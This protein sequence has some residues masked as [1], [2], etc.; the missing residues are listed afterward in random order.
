MGS[1]CDRGRFR[2]GILVGEDVS[3]ALEGVDDMGGVGCICFLWSRF[4]GAGGV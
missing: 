2:G 1:R 4:G 3:G